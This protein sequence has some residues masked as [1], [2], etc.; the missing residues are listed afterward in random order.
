MQTANG[1]TRC[2]TNRTGRKWD[3]ALPNELSREEM[4]DFTEKYLEKT[5]PNQPY[6]FAIHEKE[7]A[8]HGILN[9]HVHVM[10]A[11]Y[12]MD[13]RTSSLE[14]EEFY[15]K[16]GVSR[17]GNEYGGARRTRRFDKY[18][19]RELKK[20]RKDLADEINRVYAEK[21]IEERV[22]EKSFKELRMEALKQGDFQKAEAY[23][24]TRPRRLH[25]KKLKKYENVI[26]RKI[27]AGIHGNPRMDDVEDEEV[28]MRIY[29]EMEKELSRSAVSLVEKSRTVTPS[30]KEKRL[31]LEEE[32]RTCDELD[33]LSPVN[34]G[35]SKAAIAK[36]QEL[37]RRKQI[38]IPEGNESE[39]RFFQTE[40]YRAGIQKE[41]LDME[42][43]LFT[44]AGDKEIIRE[45]AIRLY[46]KERL[47]AMLKDDA[48][49]TA[50]R[51][52]EI[53]NLRV[54]ASH[55][56][57]RL[58][59]MKATGPFIKEHQK[60][61]QEYLRNLRL[62]NKYEIPKDKEKKPLT[63]RQQERRD[64]F[65]NQCLVLLDSYNTLLESFRDNRPKT[66]EEFRNRKEE[67]DVLR[68]RCLRKSLSRHLPEKY[69]REMKASLKETEHG[70]DFI[71]AERHLGEAEEGRIRALS[72]RM[73]EKAKEYQETW[74]K[75]IP[76]S[77]D[78]Y[79]TQI[80]DEEE[81]G[82]LTRIQQALKK[83]EKAMEVSQKE[84]TPTAGHMET[85]AGL[86]EKLTEILERGKTEDCLI[87]ARERQEEAVKAWPEKRL[88]L[89]KLETNL[90][91]H[92]EKAPIPEFQK[93]KI[94]EQLDRNRYQISRDK[95]LSDEARNRVLALEKEVRERLPKTEKEYLLA[96]IRRASR[97]ELSAKEEKIRYYR[98]ELKRA[99]KNPKDRYTPELL[100]TR[101]AQAEAERDEMIRQYTTPALRF[102]AMGEMMKARGQRKETLQD[103]YRKIGQ[104]GEQ[105]LSRKYLDPDTR[106]EIENTLGR[107]TKRLERDY[108]SLYFEHM[109]KS[110]DFYMEQIINEEEGGVLERL[111]K[112]K[113]EGETRK[114]TLEKEIE[115]ILLTKEKA[116]E[117]KSRDP[118][119]LRKREEKIREGKTEIRRIEEKLKELNTSFKEILERERTPEH[120]A[121]A[122]LRQETAIENWPKERMKVRE[123]FRLLRRHL[124]KDSMPDDV[125]KTLAKHLEKDAPTLSNERILSEGILKEFRSLESRMN[126]ILPKSENA[127]LL[128]EARKR[129]GG[130][131]EKQEGAIRYYQKAIRK[132][133]K[134]EPENAFGLKRLEGQLAGAEAARDQLITRYADAD[135]K[136]WAK[137]KREDSLK[138]QLS[139][140]EELQREITALG[141]KTLSRP[142]LT[143]ETREAVMKSLGTMAKKM[144]KEYILGYFDKIPHGPDY[145]L[146]KVIDEETGGALS[147]IREDM[148][149]EKNR[150]KM[151]EKE[152]EQLSKQ[153][154][155]KEKEIAEK[156]KAIA[157][158][159]SRLDSLKEK[160]QT[161][162]D[163]EK[164]ADRVI[165][166]QDLSRVSMEEWP[167]K[168]KALR[169]MERIMRKYLRE[170]P[171]PEEQKASMASV[172]EKHSGPASREKLVNDAVLKR[173]AEFEKR[174]TDLL[175]KSEE[176]YIL[177]E[178][179]KRSEGELDRA[180]R[181]VRYYKKEQRKIQEKD[182]LNYSREALLGQK[183]DEALEARNAVIEKYRTRDVEVLAVQ[184]RE[185][186]IAN[187]SAN[188]E[189]L[190]EEMTRLAAKE[191]N[192]K[193]LTAETR[194]ELNTILKRIT[195]KL[196]RQER[197]EAYARKTLK[198][199]TFGRKGR[200]LRELAG[201]I[202][203]ESKEMENSM[204]G[205]RASFH[206]RHGEELMR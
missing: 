120:I 175:P 77:Q 126:E 25:V 8:I 195:K 145:Y 178:I 108:T 146:G 74:Y 62:L 96:E 4:I 119:S 36:R 199:R 202:D 149:M 50:K 159:D 137:V 124:E 136:E 117:D 56:L 99:E 51:K 58:R 166:A 185:E 139:H 63:E 125:R 171:M 61:I 200:L 6:T 29:Q 75:A 190:R 87:R 194:N 1:T 41:M 135:A 15:K 100:K 65:G 92:L 37:E 174:M 39:P 105:E 80:I 196:D 151:L 27:R 17:T 131:L 10:F 83:E 177:D 53:Y 69:S 102:K 5:F 76:R 118:E 155:A 130:L 98:G 101:I 49:L 28:R 106:K 150:R 184:K 91:H 193:V 104:T 47:D 170:T 197:I 20:L 31:A 156:E 176:A 163:T 180:D 93:R 113:K 43:E 179:R 30:E 111:R 72:R 165:K 115:T 67:L 157:L 40:K 112:E 103:L 182:S 205:R 144:E 140:M 148:R 198:Y 54:T 18:G 162:L 88:E 181:I 19:N 168:R 138:N 2:D 152:K 22:T 79:V 141:K 97:G 90:D 57:E 133:E 192:R 45:Y 94:K 84:G 154:D 23:N 32:I 147:A 9:P 203:K 34:T 70:H 201:L 128:E 82:L 71:M 172:I 204:G 21:G 73:A 173:A 187:R 95:L 52:N 16:H 68:Q 11:D 26:R 161:T 158:S 127:I 12:I 122:R 55:S 46:T 189:I 110:V 132:L 59:K 123:A 14:R 64:A 42:K 183:L 48:P 186:A 160:L 13:K 3:F 167:E 86:K 38:L 142:H 35:F 24:R 191:G 89:R 7:S 107:I 66:R 121:R 78:Y 60:E 134:E 109:P 85:I 206:I 164:T 143:D 81:G 129:S 116:E 188:L 33:A 169:A 44:H 114:S 153:P